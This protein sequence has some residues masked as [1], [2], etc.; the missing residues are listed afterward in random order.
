MA[1]ITTTML[2]ELWVPEHLRG[3]YASARA[4]LDSPINIPL[5]APF[6]EDRDGLRSLCAEAVAQADYGG[7][8]PR[9]VNPNDLLVGEHGTALD[10][11]RA[12][13]QA[14]MYRAAQEAIPE[15]EQKYEELAREIEAAPERAW[16]LF[17]HRQALAGATYEQGRRR[18]AEDRERDRLAMDQCPVCL[19]SDRSVIGVVTVRRLLPDTAEFYRSCWACHVVQ[20]AA[21]VDRW[22]SAKV[23]AGKT[24]R[25]ALAAA[26]HLG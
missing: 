24:R 14:R 26:G 16:N 20:I 21:Y 13:D 6:M 3:D 9:Y 15:F 11:Q 7:V 1:K 2:P 23:T 18:D 19:E 4:A 12:G 5:L 10:R 25:D 8:D 17:L 22:G